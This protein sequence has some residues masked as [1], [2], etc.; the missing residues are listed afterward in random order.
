MPEK[1]HRIPDAFCDRC[2]AGMTQDEAALNRKLINRAATTCLC[3]ACL[4]A[5]FGTDVEWLYDRMNFFRRQGCR[6]FSPWT[7]EDEPDAP[8]GK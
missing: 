4:A 5:Q 3:P 6:L 8:D 1:R 7:G 2:G